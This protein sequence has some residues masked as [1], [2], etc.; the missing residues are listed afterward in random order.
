M[1]RRYPLCDL[2]RHHRCAA[3]PLS[4]SLPSPSFAR[5]EFITPIAELLPL[6]PETY[7]RVI[8]QRKPDKG[9]YVALC[10]ILSVWMITPLAW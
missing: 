8:D 3:M 7:P 5:D 10:L 6:P 4:I 2:Q 9:Y 1:V